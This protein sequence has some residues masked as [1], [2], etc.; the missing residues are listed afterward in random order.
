MENS[1]YQMSLPEQFE[2]FSEA[3][4]NGFI[5]VKDLK[6]Q[7]K[8]I[9]GT[10]CA[11]TPKEVLDAAGMISVAL[12]GT[13]EETIGDA[14]RILPRN[15]CPLIKSS[16][17]FAL[18]NK[19]P[20][21]Y[22]SDIIIG[23]TTCDGKK[24][25]YELLEEM[26]KNVH[27]MHLPQGAGRHYSIDIWAEEIKLLIQRIEEQF[28]IKITEEMLRDAV[29]YN[30]EHRKLREELFHL[31]QLDPPP[32]WGK[33]IIAVTEG[34]GYQFDQKVRRESILTLLDSVKTAYAAG[35]R[36]VS[37][38]AKRI[39]LTGCPLGGALEKICNAI[40][41]NGGVVVCYDT[42]GGTRS[43]GLLVD[44]EDPDVIH[45]IAERYMKVGCSVLTPNQTRLDNLPGLIQDYKVDGVI[46]VILQACHTYNVEAA[47]IK[48]IVEK[49]GVPYMSLETDYS[50]VD[51]GQINTR[52]EAFLEML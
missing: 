1:E 6:Q 35:E 32:M 29:K 43:S 5:Q 25:M 41:N 16:F 50:Q 30:N 47:R 48:R 34:E 44:E 28:G 21:T 40:E 37:K 22:F 13:S 38:S 4:R 45:A 42:C 12:C 26:G 7:G 52:I 33:D 3:R 20:Y 49:A 14:E 27:V 9:A 8:I 18:T 17:G 11:Y 36:P 31:Q 24:K 23:E 51:T 19:C 39:L 10:F 2:S 15:L 46:E